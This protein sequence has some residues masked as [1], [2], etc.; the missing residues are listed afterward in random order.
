MFRRL[1]ISLCLLL[2]LFLLSACKGK[3]VVA[4]PTLPPTHIA[5][6]TR[7]PTAAA[8]QAPSA[9]LVP[10]PSATPSPAGPT[11]TRTRQPSRTPTITRTRPPTMTRTV[12]K[13]P[14]PTSTSRPHIV[15]ANVFDTPVLLDDFPGKW[16]P[17][18]NEILF[19]AEV[20]D[21]WKCQVIKSASPAFTPETLAV[22]ASCDALTWSP[23]GTS[24]LFSGPQPEDAPTAGNAD[25]S[26][27]WVVERT[28]KGL[29][30]ISPDGCAFRLLMFWGWMGAQN[31]VYSDYGGGGHILIVVLNTATSETHAQT[32]FPGEAYP[33]NSVYIPA[34][35]TGPN[36]VLFV[37]AEK[38]TPTPDPLGNYAQGHFAY[39]PDFAAIPR[40][41]A[42]AMFSDWLPGTNQILVFWQNEV[43][44][45]TNLLLWDVDKNSVNLLAPNG[46]GG[47]FSPD[48]KY[49]V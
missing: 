6:P 49:L 45:K 4:T 23:D 38:Y 7:P 8:T 14:N 24:I 40:S 31:L 32:F 37:I 18:R 21:S 33:P 11:A 36:A 16:S 3:P 35:S 20:P 46:L 47:F 26:A 30:R 41:N 1:S 2:S 19:F 39:M 34:I 42:S 9:T 29:R 28:G 15:S 44:Y 43:N 22:E 17:T 10:A 13:T 12:T 27:I 48:G 25:Y 5:A